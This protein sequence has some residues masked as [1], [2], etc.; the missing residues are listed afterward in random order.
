MLGMLHRAAVLRDDVLISQPRYIE[1]PVY[2]R[3][4]VYGG[5]RSNIG[6]DRIVD[7][8]VQVPQQTP[9]HGRRR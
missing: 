7:E 4:R 5:T 6:A 1:A 2:V 8:D 9:T 3:M